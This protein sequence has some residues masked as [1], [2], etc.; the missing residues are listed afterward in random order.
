MNSLVASEQDRNDDPEDAEAMRFVAALGAT[1]ASANYPVT[2]VRNTMVATSKTYGLD[3]QFLTLPNYVQVGTS[4]GG[5]RT[6][7][8]HPDQDLRFD[9]TFPLAT[10]IAQAQTGAIDPAEGSA[11]LDR[12]W[13]MAPRFRAW[14]GVIGYTLQ[15]AGLSLILQP[16]PLTLLLAVALGTVVGVLCEIARRNDAL[17]QLLPTVCAFTVSLAAFAAVDKLHLPDASLRA[18]AP[19]LAIFLPGAAITLAVAELSTRQMVSGSSR[20][21]AG[22]MRIAQLAFGILIAA[23][24]A[25]IAESNLVVT[26]VNRLG[27]WAPWAGIVVYGVGAFL[28]FGP[29]TRF[30][31]WLMAMLFIAYVGQLAGNALFGS[32]ASGFGGGLMLTLCALAVAHRPN[33]PAAISLI[34]PGFWLLVPGSLGLMGV[35]QLLGTDNTTVLTATLISMISIALGMQTGLLLWRA[36]VQLTS[37]R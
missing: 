33:T 32:Y 25:G 27:I 21:V 13:R 17:Q 2:M 5:G 3:N 4:R 24:V 18:L 28:C 12:I 19:P 11:E 16:A 30:L 23:Q 14:V 6:Y 1:M 7:I 29:P 35:T 9:Q 8:S 20:L 36:T 22:L 26:H 34:L 31:P 15:S 37:G 10:L